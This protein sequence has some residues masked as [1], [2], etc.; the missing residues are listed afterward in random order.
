[1]AVVESWSWR[2]VTNKVRKIFYFAVRTINT[3]SSVQMT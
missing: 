2:C 3:N 1:V